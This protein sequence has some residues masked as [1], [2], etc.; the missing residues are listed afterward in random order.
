MFFFQRT[1]ILKFPTLDVLQLALGH[2]E[3]AD[4]VGL[5]EAQVGIDDQGQWLIQ[6]SVSPSRRVLAELKKRGVETLRSTA[7]PLT[8][9]VRTWLE[10]IP[11]TRESET[12]LLPEQVAILFDLPDASLLA[13]LSL[14]M[15]RLGNDRQGVRWLGEEPTD[16]NASGKHRALLRVI[17][18]P[19]YSLLRALAPH[20]ATRAPRAFVERAPQ[21]WVELGYNHPLVSKIRPAKNEVLLLAAPQQWTVLP[22]GA[23]RDL[24]EILEFRIPETKSPW[25]EEKLP[26][27]LRVTIRLDRSGG[28]DEAE[29]WVL[30]E[31]P[32]E[33]L[34]QFVQH[35]EDHL[36]QR[37]AFA[38]GESA[39]AQVIVLRVRPSKLPPPILVLQAESYAPFRKMPNLFLP[40]GMT[41]TPTLRRD[42][43]RKR[44][45]DDPAIVTWLRPTTPGA[46]IPET[47]PDTAFRPLLDWVEYVLDHEHQPLQAWVQAS[48][49]DFEGFLC[50]EE[51]EKKPKKPPADRERPRPV[52]KPGEPREVDL[53]DLSTAKPLSRPDQ[54]HEEL[55]SLAALLR[56]EPS[57]VQLRLREVEDQFLSFEGPLDLPE[58]QALWPEMAQLNA[59]LKNVED[60]GL[61]WLHALWPLET[62]P[63]SWLWQWVVTEAGA[64]PE[65]PDRPRGTPRTWTSVARQS[66]GSPREIPGEDLDRLLALTDP[67][68]ADVRALCAYLIWAAQQ[69]PVPPAVVQRLNQLQRYLEAHEQLLP[70]RAVWLAWRSLVE[71]TEGDVLALA[72]ARDRILERLFKNGLRPEQ[73]LPGFLRFAGQPTSQRFRQ[74]R[75]WMTALCQQ[76]HTWAKQIAFKLPAPSEDPPRV[77]TR[78]QTEG[79]GVRATHAYI[80]LI[81]AFGLARVGESDASKELVTQAETILRG[82]MDEVHATLLAAFVYRIAQ[83]REGKPVK[84][85]LSPDLLQRIDKV[86]DKM[87]R[88][89]IDRLREKSRILEPDHKINAFSPWTAR[90]TPLDSSLA[91]LNELQ[92]RKEIVD[93]VQ[94]LLLEVPRSKNAPEQRG[95]ILCQAMA[96]A[97]SVGEE[98][99]LDM[100]NRLPA[101]Y[102][103]LGNTDDPGD[104]LAQSELLEKGLFLAAHFDRVEFMPTLVTRFQNLLHALHGAGSLKKLDTLAAQCFRGLRKLGMRDEI[105]TLLHQIADLIL[106]GKDLAT[107][108]PR[109]DASGAEALRALLHVAAGWFFFG[110]DR[111][112][113][114]IIHAT[115][116]ILFQGALSNVE[117]TRLASAYALTIGQA[118][119]EAAQKGLEELLQRLYNV[120][121]SFTTNSHYLLSQ[122]DLIESV[123]QAIVNDEFT[124]GAD[125]R[126]WL[127]DDEF[128]V[129]RRLHR[130]LRHLMSQ[131]HS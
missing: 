39:G 51:T 65:R 102:D 9:H 127:D 22:E 16:E 20:E 27:R 63:T 84:G 77:I 104:L 130:D 89:R 43:V 41:L 1:M 19:Y 128:L 52:R 11:L 54:L 122:L 40:C 44:L 119:V 118:P 86:T 108:N 56:T 131:T 124:L 96:L 87:Q 58:R 26:E 112:A 74:V 94:R 50:D 66:P 106:A 109:A 37:L 71:M 18:P 107:F 6:P 67:N 95:R 110:R 7:V 61:C 21:V 72:R 42:V 91:E 88:F 32:Y 68:L 57:K 24:Y 29:L 36:I 120:W 59:A 117:Q 25:R 31:N 75:Q 113:E 49:F 62:W 45:A 85:P 101:A 46:F 8:R 69:D 98:F 53:Q 38:V 28:S 126:R 123:V 14:E 10:L 97:P 93:R 30:R 125:A 33:Q 70:V 116:T 78:P 17:G 3:I 92:D 64:V 76:A 60:A 34:N 83:A 114:P 12:P 80:D 105:D 82:V 99:A 81:F 2:Q 90:S 55:E 115:R 5:A 103:A 79:P 129:R 13:D 47:L 23:Y 121:D 73:D 35:A 48:H 4:S 111:Q 15:L 100:L